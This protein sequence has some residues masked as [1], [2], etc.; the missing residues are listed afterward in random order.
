MT[1]LQVYEKLFKF[2]RLMCS[3]DFDYVMEG[4]LYEAE[5]KQKVIRMQVTNSCLSTTLPIN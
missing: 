5:L 2:G 3:M 1:T 4:L